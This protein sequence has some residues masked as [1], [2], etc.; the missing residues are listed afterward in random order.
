MVNLDSFVCLQL[1][2]SQPTL[3]LLENEKDLLWV[4]VGLYRFSY[5]LSLIELLGQM[6]K[7]WKPQILLFIHLLLLP[8]DIVHEFLDSLLDTLLDSFLHGLRGH[9]LLQLQSIEF[10]LMLRLI[11][12]LKCGKGCL[13]FPSRVPLKVVPCLGGF[14][15]VEVGLR[16]ALIGFEF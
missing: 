15:K 16:D 11:D 9:L 6:T 5:R 8:K 3:S 7:V 14:P 4:G 12:F 1:L 13:I 2:F 10:I